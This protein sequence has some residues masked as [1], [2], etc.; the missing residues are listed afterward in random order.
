MDSTLM[1]ERL[2]LE[3]YEGK[4]KPKTVRLARK[5]ISPGEYIEHDAAYKAVPMCVR[6]QRDGTETTIRG[7]QAVSDI[8]AARKMYNQGCAALWYL[9]IPRLEEN[10]NVIIWQ[11]KNG[12]TAQGVCGET[13][14][15]LRGS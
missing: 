10:A 12:I 13:Y 8:V 6:T 4:C 5:T 15:V 14:H 7:D 11:L 3:P 2:A 9:K 1:L